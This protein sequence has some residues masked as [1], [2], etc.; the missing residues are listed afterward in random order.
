MLLSYSEGMHSR[1]IE[2]IEKITFH[3]IGAKNN[4]ASATLDVITTS[5]WYLSRHSTIGAAPRYVLIPFTA[6]TKR[7]DSALGVELEK[8]GGQKERKGKE[9]TAMH[10]R[11]VDLMDSSC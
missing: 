7:R 3:T 2:L 11:V 1:R 5:G 10:R 9:S 4:A 6:R 8:S